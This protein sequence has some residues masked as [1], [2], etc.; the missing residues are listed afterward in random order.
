MKDGSR[1]TT[2][3]FQREFV[4]HSLVLERQRSGIERK[5]KGG[6]KPK[7]LNENERL[8]KGRNNTLSAKANI[9]CDGC[10]SFGGHLITLMWLVFDRDF[11]FLPAGSG[12]KQITT[13]GKE[14]DTDVA[15]ELVA[16][17]A[18]TITQPGYVYIYLSNENDTPVQVYFD[19][20]KVTH[21]KSPVEQM[22]DYYP[23]GLAFNSYSREN[24]VAQDYKYNGKEEQTELGLGWI[25]FEV[26]MYQP[27]LGRMNS[28][29]PH[30]F[31]YF[32]SSPY[33]FVLNNPLLFSDPTGMDTTT[34]VKPPLVGPPPPAPLPPPGTLAP[35]TA[36]QSTGTQ[37]TLAGSIVAGGMAAAVVLAADDVT[38]LGVADDPAIPVVVVGALV[39]GGLVWA[40]DAVFNSDDAGLE[41]NV[42]RN[43]AQDKPLTKGDI[44]KLQE[45]GWTH[46]DKGDN[47]GKTDLY[48][49]KQGNVYQKPKGGNGPGEPIGVNLN[50]L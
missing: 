35:P 2:N 36:T 5:R 44:E 17:P 42:E 9:S 11:N 25:D 50:D 21:T 48:K 39:I 15:H 3:A 34:A 4:N 24:S 40:W 28:I 7:E 38:V 6:T 46:R 20:F 13:A 41:E 37:T 1:P 45:N 29:D 33:A 12:F 18:I 49:D 47:G 14:A 30:Y 32:H 16:S 26:R 27:E 19:D 23:F 31:N 43:P 8:L 10:E 22:D